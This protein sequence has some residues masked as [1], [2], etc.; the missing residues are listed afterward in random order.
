MYRRKADYLFKRPGSDNWWLRLQYPSVMARRPLQKSLRTQDRYEAEIRALPMIQAHKLDVYEAKNKR[1]ET[2]KLTARRKWP[3]GE[4]VLADG[5]RIISTEWSALMLKDGTLIGETRDQ[6]DT[7]LNPRFD[8]VAFRDEAIRDSRKIETGDDTAIL[9][10]YLALKKRNIYY[11]REARDTWALFKRLVE[12]KAL[13]SCTRED[14]RK[15]IAHLQ[16]EG[17]K[18]ATIVKKLNYLSA[19]VNHAIGEGVLSFNPF[20]KIAPPID[21]ATRRVPYEDD[22][23]ERVALALPS[24]DPESRLLWVLLASTGMRL[25]EAFHITSERV[26]K[27]I[28][29]VEIGS[30][31]EQSKRRLPLPEVV[32]P[33]LPERIIG[34][35]FASNAK[36]LGRVL[37]RLVRKAGADGK[38]KVLHSLR[39]RA[40]DRMRAEQCPIAVQYELFGHEEKTVAAGY[41]HGSPMSVLKPWIDKIIGEGS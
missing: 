18:A 10:A 9:E 5:T 7:D 12:G 16:G 41:G 3:L 19:A 15:L 32:L 33:L 25:G 37:Q 27:G 28:R 13:K 23:M 39:H 2:F 34:P 29:Y 4:S 6:W 22:D 31:N 26:E 8:P 21:D 24:F 38:G 36:N 11:E 1:A 14:G 17:D 30:K 20:A 40:K 35:I